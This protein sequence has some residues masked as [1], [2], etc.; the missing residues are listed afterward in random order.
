[1]ISH[2]HNRHRICLIGASPDTGNLGLNALCHAVVNGLASRGVEG[3]SI[4]DRALGSAGRL[5]ALESPDGPTPVMFYGAVNCSRY[6]R[7]S[8]LWN[9]RISARLGGLSNPAAMAIRNASAIMDISSGDSFSDR[10]GKEAFQACALPKFIAIDNGKPLFLLPQTFST[11]K[12]AGCRAKAQF[13]LQNAAQVWAR[14]PQSYQALEDLLGRDFDPH[15]HRQGV[16]MAFGLRTIKPSRVPD[17]LLEWK[18]SKAD[19]PIIGLNFSGRL[20]AQSVAGLK[21]GLKSDYGQ[22]ARNIVCWMLTH[23]NTRIMLIPHV[24]DAES[25]IGTDIGAYR[26]ILSKIDPEYRDRVKIIDNVSHP[27]IIKWYIGQADWFLGSRLHAT[28]ASISQGV[29]TLALVACDKFQG[30]FNGCGQRAAVTDMRLHDRETVLGFVV[31]SWCNR[32][33]TRE[34][35]IEPIGQI[36]LR[37]AQQLDALVMTQPLT[38][39]EAYQ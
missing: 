19:G 6:Y 24:F 26:D 36:K 16:D 27:C 11:F 29:P 8:N 34:A 5:G 30:I 37:W 13:I 23:T 4:F 25:G 38:S 7:Q 12:D 17:W 31:R 15:L 35:L 1:M 2:I 14:D 22:L 10:Y 39:V 21:L 18:Q 32:A 3:I 9:I 28:I 33:Q 20:Y